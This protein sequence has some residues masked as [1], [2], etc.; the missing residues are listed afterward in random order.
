MHT[1]KYKP[2]A[3]APAARFNQIYLKLRARDQGSKTEMKRWDWEKKRKI[4]LLRRLIFKPPPHCLTVCNI[5][6]PWSLS[7]AL[8]CMKLCIYIS[9]C[10]TAQFWPEFIFKKKK[11]IYTGAALRYEFT[12]PKQE[13]VG[14]PSPHVL[15]SDT[16]RSTSPPVVADGG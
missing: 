3:C 16:R 15:N 12:F 9:V 6:T 4:K 14:A 10:N 13:R 7:A 5:P 8:V 1:D 11:K 2:A